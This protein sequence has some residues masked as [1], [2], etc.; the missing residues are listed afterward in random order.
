MSGDGLPANWD[1]IPDWL[2]ERI[3]W[4]LECD[5]A[6]TLDDPEIRKLA[7]WVGG[8]LAECIVEL[9]ESEY[10]SR[11]GRSVLRRLFRRRGGVP[12]ESAEEEWKVKLEQVFDVLEELSSSPNPDVQNFVQVSV[13]ENFPGGKLP[14]KVFRKLQRSFRDRLKP[15]SRRLWDE[16]AP[17]IGEYPDLES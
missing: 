10:L 12:E 9:L 14:D 4:L 13:Y 15:A 17:Y 16:W 8:V 2:L 6:G 3:P 5:R 7:E 1:E 11:K